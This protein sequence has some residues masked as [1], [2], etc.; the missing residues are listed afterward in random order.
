MDFT[1]VLNSRQSIRTF[2]GEPASQDALK[3][4]LHGA[5][6]S[7]V[8]MGKYESLHLTV[9]ESKDILA[10]IEKNTADVFKNHDRSFLYGA[11]QLIV[12]STAQND[13]VG[14]SNAAIVAQDMALAATNEGI[15]ACLIWGCIMA[16]NTNRELLSKL[17][18]PEGFKP[19]CA[20][21]IGQFDGKYTEREIP[22]N[23][24]STTYFS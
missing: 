7:P 19:S 4:I 21:A 22:E 23:R 9:I 20:V 8:G 24:I 12:V 13:N 3:A 14:F 16:L 5:N 15:G 1:E 10:Q 2:N 18:L 17:N 11:P 6:A